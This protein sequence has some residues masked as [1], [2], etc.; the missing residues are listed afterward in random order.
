MSVLTQLQQRFDAALAGLVPDA[1]AR[2][3]FVEMIKPTTD[4]KHGDYQANCAMSLAKELDRKPR[5]VAEEIV[6]RLPVEDMLE[7]PQVAGRGFINLKLKPEWLAKQLQGMAADDRL[8]VPKAERPKTYVIDYSSPNVAKPLHVG[9][10]RST[11]IGDSLKRILR[12]LGHTVIADNHLGD[13]GTQ[14]GM[15]IYGYKQFRNEEALQTDPIG[16]LERLYLH[17]RSL[18]KGQEDDEGD[19]QRTLDEAAHYARCLEETAKLQA[20]DPENYAIW[21]RFVQYTRSTIDPLY[22]LL[23]VK[24]DQ[25]HGESF[26]RGMLPGVVESLLASGVAEESEG[27]VV[28][29]LKPAVEGEERRADAVIR[30]KDG[31][32][33]YMTSDLATIQYR[34][35]EWK[36]DAILYVVGTPQSHHF[37]TLFEAARR[38]GYTGV[39]LQHIE[40][41]SVLGNDKR[42]LSTRNG[43]ASRLEELLDMAISRG[44]AM[45]AEKRK[46]RTE[47][48]YTDPELPAAEWQMLAERVGIGAVK[49]ADLSQNRTSDYLFSWD[50]MLSLSGNSATYMQYAYTRCR[51]IFREG[52]VDPE[53]LRQLPPL[54]S[55]G[56]E[57][58]RQLALQLARFEDVLRAAAAEYLPHLLTGYLWDLCKTYSGFFVNCPVL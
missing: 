41:G 38:W 20:E 44:G 56:T 10:L 53:S 17:V 3:K 51:S 9:H 57:F 36:P 35:K 46:E 25:F 2:R 12:F 45:C 28:M 11:I 8:G 58:E 43:G 54:L 1:A 13:W 15:L 4:A 32:F 16:E 55:L 6:K 47:L 19:V 40:F 24:F 14:F 5:D 39:E 22:E 37:K 33:T 31:A 23:E 49:Y 50:K 29:F 30:K 18:T 21:Q 7:P 48:G 34:V 52:A 27:A 42:P 26:Y